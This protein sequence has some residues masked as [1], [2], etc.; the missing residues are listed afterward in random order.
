MTLWF[1][2]L[3]A[4][5]AMVWWVASLAHADNKTA[6]STIVQIEI[7]TPGHQKHAL[8]HGVVWLAHDKSK[9]NYRWGGEHC[10]GKTLAPQFVALLTDAFRNKQYV[11]IH[12]GKTP[13]K[14]RTYRCITGLTIA[15]N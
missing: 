1:K 3:T 8:Y 2:R 11:T 5:I 7:L 4:A 6:T 13:F 10:G 9:Y 15:H 12:Y 14:N